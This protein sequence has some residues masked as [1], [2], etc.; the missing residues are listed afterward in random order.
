MQEYAITRIFR[1]YDFGSVKDI[2]LGFSV[3]P[4]DLYMVK[5]LQFLVGTTKVI[6][7]N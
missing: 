4:I 1:Y 6:I 7:A 2:L 5:I 3:L